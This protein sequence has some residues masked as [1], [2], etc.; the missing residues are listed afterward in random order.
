MYTRF[1]GFREKPFRQVPNPDFLFL[2]PTH[3]EALAH[4]N[5][6]LAEGEG[7]LMIT[8][9]VGTGKSTLCRA[10]FQKLDPDVACAYIFNSKL[11]PLHLLRSINTEFGAP[12]D[13]DTTHELVE[14][15]N[16][17]LI[18]KRASGQNVIIVIDEAQN[19]PVESLE[20]VRLLSNLETT[21]EKLLQLVLVGQ[22]ELA[23][24]IDSFELRQLGQ[25]IHLACHL[26]PLS[27][28]ETVQYIQHRIELVSQ[29]PQMPFEKGALRAIY[30]FS[31][32]VPRLINTACDRMLLAAYLKNRSR[33]STGMATN[34][35]DELQRRGRP[36]RRAAVPWARAALVAC[37][38]LAAVTAGWLVLNNG[39]AP[40]FISQGQKQKNTVAA[41]A[42][43]P[44][45][46][47][48]GMEPAA[49]SGPE[50]GHAEGNL[51]LATGTEEE[52][53][54]EMEKVLPLD[55]FLR[56]IRHDDTRRMALEA[57]LGRWGLEPQ[58]SLPLDVPDDDAYFDA[59]AERHGLSM[60]VIQ[61]D[62]DALIDLDL[63]AVITLISPDDGQP[64]YA[65]VVGIHDGRF[66]LAV[67]GGEAHARTDALTLKRIWGGKAFI[68]WKNYMGY[69]GV[70]PGGA[71]RA[72]VVLLKQLLW[73]I[74]YAQ[75]I[76]DD[77]Y[78]EATRQAVREIQAKHGL[79][80]DG[81]VGNMTK[82]ALFNEKQSLPIP[83][84]SKRPSAGKGTN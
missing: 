18:D 46:V 35:I 37:V 23:E 78:D 54:P 13:A 66:D 3:E 43:P 63:P 9:D 7:F 33:I 34:I 81:L 56:A 48:A 10:F 45:M 49:A 74:G 36:P 29:K 76:I 53:H 80:V 14:S 68:P 2:S 20:Q 65:G 79:V 12:A 41:S 16:A 22:P 25:R 21:R 61:E 5:Y 71:P 59:M 40:K 75:L 47:K 77:R 4:L 32:G 26:R 38:V 73:E 28:D 83:H 27:F 84:L 31:Q 60:L 72:A 30:A 17:F 44:E 58:G 67:Q 70:I 15:L 50:T 24:V 39:T 11:D 51:T 42:A 52:S 1:W 19:L 82:I 69:P 64:L 55:E 8:G 57:V 62:I 6:A